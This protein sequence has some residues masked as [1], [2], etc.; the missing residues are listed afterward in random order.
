M[1]LIGTPYRL[2]I[3]HVC[4]G[5]GGQYAVHLNSTPYTLQIIYVCMGGGQYVVQSGK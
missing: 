3:I 2:R 1:H 4:M 5:G